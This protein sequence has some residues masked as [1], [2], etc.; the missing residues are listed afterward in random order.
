V[1]VSPFVIAEEPGL[2]PNIAL[3]LLHPLLKTVFVTEDEQRLWISNHFQPFEIPFLRIWDCYLGSQPDDEN[4]MLSRALRQRL[5]TLESRKI[6]LTAHINYRVWEP[7]P[8]IS[9]TTSPAAIQELADWRAKRRGAQT[10]T[11]LD[12]SSVVP[13]LPIKRIGQLA[14]FFPAV[15]QYQP[16]DQ[17][18]PN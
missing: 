16:V 14:H 9:F 15:R 12:S 13:H 2:S 1:V 6:S 8:Y 17:L 5:D 4:R 10:L 11:V 7:T 18:A 3:S